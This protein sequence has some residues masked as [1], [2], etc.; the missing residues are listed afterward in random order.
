MAKKQGL[1]LES[2]DNDSEA[3]RKYDWFCS[4][5]AVASLHWQTWEM[6]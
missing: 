3:Y 5:R 4:R 2:C 6:W 1:A